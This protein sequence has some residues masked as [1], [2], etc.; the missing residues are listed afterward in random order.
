LQ[1]FI[2]N[3]SRIG[4]LPISLPQGVTVSVDGSEVSVKG[5]KGDLKRH[6][7]KQVEVEVKDGSVWVY[8]KGENK[9]VRTMHGT[10]RSHLSNM[11]KG[12]SEGWQ[13]QLE[14]VGSGYRAEVRGDELVLIVG[15]SHPVPMKLPQG[16][17]AKV[18]KN[19]ITLEC[20]DKEVLG[21]FSAK[22]R[23]VR[24]PEPYKGKGILYLGEV[25]RRKAG[26]A[27]AG[28]GAA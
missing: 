22:V 7:P 1:K 10:Y 8:P 3:M 23:E 12:V 28:A 6:F 9:L 14:I 13:K 5:P 15:Y 2:K 24:P 21:G 11:V 4:K 19:V 26:K 20:A 25:I 27:A 18:E 16:V 17:S